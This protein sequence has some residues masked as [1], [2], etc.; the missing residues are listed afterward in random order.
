MAN[1]ETFPH[2]LVSQ[3]LFILKKSKKKSKKKESWR[4]RVW[5]GGKR[6]WKRREERGEKRREEKRRERGEGLSS[7]TF[8]SVSCS[9]VVPLFLLPPPQD[10][11]IEKKRKKSKKERGEGV[12]VCVMQPYLDRIQSASIAS[13]PN[14]MFP[15][16]TDLL[17][18]TLNEHQYDIRGRGRGE[19]RKGGF[20]P[21]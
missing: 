4:N 16:C 14:C 3:N 7:K 12:S 1:V 8:L 11:E 13:E 10:G 19:R 5:R 21:I 18:Q 2:R 17:Y 20:G 9:F 15:N 6:G